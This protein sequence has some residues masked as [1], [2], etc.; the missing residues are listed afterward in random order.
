MFNY[1]LEYRLSSS[2]GLEEFTYILN[3]C[4]DAIMLP[5]EL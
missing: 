5:T 4:L 2:K 1:D 3:K